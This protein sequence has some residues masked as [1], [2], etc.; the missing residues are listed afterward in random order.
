MKTLFFILLILI[1]EIT[2][3]Q[4]QNYSLANNTD[5]SFVTD[6]PIVISNKD[7]QSVYF[8]VPKYNG[9][10]SLFIEKGLSLESLKIEELTT[11]QTY[12]NDFSMNNC[13]VGFSHFSATSGNLWFFN[14]SVFKKCMQFQVRKKTGPIDS[15]IFIRDT[16]EY[17]N[18]A[19]CYNV[20]DSIVVT[21]LLQFNNCRV[22]NGTKFLGAS[23]NKVYLHESVFNSFLLDRCHINDLYFYNNIFYNDFLISDITIKNTFNINNCR[24]DKNM[25][26]ASAKGGVFSFDDTILPDTIEFIGRTPSS[27]VFDFTKA[28]Y[29]TRDKKIVLILNEFEPKN[30]QL[31][32]KYFKLYFKRPRDTF[33]VK[34]N[35]VE[36]TYKAL[37]EGF[38]LRGDNESYIS[39]DIDYHDYKW[40]QRGPLVSWVHVFP[41]YFNR[42]GHDYM[43]VQYWIL[44]LLIF[45]TI[46]NFF[47]LNT[48]S[49]DVY[50]FDNIPE[51]KKYPR[52]RYYYKRLGFSF[53]YTAFV[54][55]TIN[56]KFE[57]LK[58]KSLFLT[59]YFFIIYI[60]G[61]IT[62]YIYAKKVLEIM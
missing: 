6:T 55:F 20:F 29:T 28:N 40:E 21:S 47:I 19:Q 30:I 60:T 8:G 52:R 12:I 39:L 5:A 4:A 34:P 25:I 32:Y 17:Y 9:R 26:I 45:Y 7:Y 41:K 36:Y 10:N 37:L 23:L 43:N 13:K 57:K 14:N 33:L 15:L 61:L 54:F 62:I 3:V 31:E 44:L 27:T 22:N 56:I 59:I 16:F 46:V 18:T 1:I 38:K 48:L 58:L 50:S 24:F 2:T 35:D 42:Y 51:I 49:K 53:A 11:K